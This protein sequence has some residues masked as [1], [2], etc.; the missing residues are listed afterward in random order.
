MKLLLDTHVWLWSQ[1]DPKRLARRAARA[2]ESPANELWLSPISV[3]ELI[4]LA[5]AG[6]VRLRKDP[7]AWV[8]EALA[9]QPL[10]EAALTREVA[11]ASRR[12]ALPHQ[13]AADRFL[14]ATAVVYGLQL[15]TAD[16]RLLEAP[17]LAT[18]DAR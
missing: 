8:E 1:A 13:D 14:A 6:R 7:I 17:G 2:L 16:D 5:E 3:W 15:V 4:L 12:L 10:R 9:L 11:I 18:L